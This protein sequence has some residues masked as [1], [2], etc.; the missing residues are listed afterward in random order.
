MLEHVAI[1]S[2]MV[3]VCAHVRPDL[4]AQLREA[5]LAWW[6]RNAR[7]QETLLALKQDTA[8]VEDKHGAPEP[9]PSVISRREAAEILG[10][11]RA[12]RLSLCHQVEEQAQRGNLRFVGSCGEVLRNLSSGHLDYRPPGN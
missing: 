2:E 6:R 8:K 4:G 7:V 5:W 3:R 12:L 1:A 9:S 10:V 11:Y